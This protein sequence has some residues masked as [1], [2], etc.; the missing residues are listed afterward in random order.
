MQNITTK[1][2]LE[3]ICGQIVEMFLFDA[4]EGNASYLKVDH[5]KEKGTLKIS[6]DG[7]FYQYMDPLRKDPASWINMLKVR[8][9]HPSYALVK[10]LKLSNYMVIES[11]KLKVTY[12]CKPN[13]DTE[14]P[15]TTV[16]QSSLQ[17]GMEVTFTEYSKGNF[18]P[19]EI[20]PEL[21]LVFLVQ[22]IFNGEI[23]T[24]PFALNGEL[25]FSETEI[26][27]VHVESDG[28]LDFEDKA[29]IIF[30]N[31]VVAMCF[32]ENEDGYP[33]IV[34]LNAEHTDQA[35]LNPDEFEKEVR[36]TITKLAK[37]LSII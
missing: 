37:Q 6:H 10:A 36:E 5:D 4:V 26:G 22:I 29:I 25:E 27:T 14:S 16:N 33:H 1:Q 12:E 13:K 32:G 35:S 23:F 31:K 28:D 9:D 17:E 11:L 18:I 19:D 21:A 20:V 30:K 34:H 8:H 24:S 3:Q 7:Y 15:R 2:M